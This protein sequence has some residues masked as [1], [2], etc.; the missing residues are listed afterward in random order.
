MHTLSPDDLKAIREL[1]LAEKESL[2]REPR[3]AL[4]ALWHPAN[5]SVED[6]VPLI[7]DQFVA[8]NFRKQSYEKL[9]KI[10]AALDRLDT[11]EFGICQACEVQIP[12]KRLLA[13]PWAD[14]CV[15]CQELLH[16]GASRGLA[17]GIAA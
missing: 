14:L 8:L 3:S 2:L 5:L 4:D 17:V 9:R 15:P 13:I 11:G 1:L 16:E 10:D 6:R 12:R 7:H